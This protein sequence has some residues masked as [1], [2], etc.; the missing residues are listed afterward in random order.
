MNENQGRSNK[1]IEDSSK[2]IFYTLIAIGIM[3][4]GLVII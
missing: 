3:V 4:I 1:K 2:I